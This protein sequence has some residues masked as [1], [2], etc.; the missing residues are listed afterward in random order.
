VKQAATFRLRMEKERQAWTE[1][2]RQ[3]LG[4]VKAGK[5]LEQYA[6]ENP[7]VELQSDSCTG[8]VDCR[9]RKGPEFAGALAALNPG[10]KHGVVETNWGAFIIRCDERTVAATLEPATY[11]E[12]RRAQVG[13]EVM[14]ELLKQ[15]EV[16]DYRDALTY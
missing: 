3:A 13:Q 11:V 14:G 15:P 9:R 4:A 10:E 16:R 2:A 12:Q 6:A 7:G 5:T 1:L 8:I